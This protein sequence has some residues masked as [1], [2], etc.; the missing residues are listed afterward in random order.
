MT[1]LRDGFALIPG[2]D[3]VRVTRSIIANHNVEK[4]RAARLL[5]QALAFVGAYAAMGLS[6][7]L[8]AL[9]FTPWPSADV[10]LAWREL[11]A[12]PVYERLSLDLRYFVVRRPAQ[13]HTSQRDI[14]RT[15]IAV[16]HVGF[17]VRADE[18]PDE[19]PAELF[20]M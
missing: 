11:E 16:E 8:E 9:D 18:W 14:H 12:D 2:E 4:G 17:N 19:E 6:G 20:A 5:D 13:T 15:A 7:E 10:D 3:F 1:E